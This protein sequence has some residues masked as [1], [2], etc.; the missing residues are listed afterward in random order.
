[1]RQDGDNSQRF[2][3]IV[4]NLVEK[5]FLFLV[6]GQNPGLFLYQIRVHL[7]YKSF[8]M[9]QYLGELQGIVVVGPVRLCPS[10][11]HRYFLPEYEAQ[12]AFSMSQCRSRNAAI[13]VLLNH[14]KRSI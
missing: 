3:S 12:N 7:R 10:T 11:N 1:M 9:L 13:A 4:K 14:G 5:G 2:S 8:D 6:F